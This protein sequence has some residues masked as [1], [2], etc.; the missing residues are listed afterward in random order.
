MVGLTPPPV[1]ERVKKLQEKGVIRRY[2]AILD[3]ELLGKSFTAYIAVS[4]A[5]HQLKAL[6]KF[7][8]AIMKLPEVLE[9]HHITGD[10]DFLLKVVVNDTADYEQFILK[11]L[12]HLPGLQ[13]LQTHVV[14]SSVKAE[15]KIPLD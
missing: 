10:A 7:E 6:R 13:R 9:C 12:S 8:D 5:A 1:L 4:L 11:K 2:A 14:L 15:T 3:S